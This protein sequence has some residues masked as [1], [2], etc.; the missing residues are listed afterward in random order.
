MDFVQIA[1]KMTF[2][3]SFEASWFTITSHLTKA[4]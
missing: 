1:K 3:L 2:E 4:N